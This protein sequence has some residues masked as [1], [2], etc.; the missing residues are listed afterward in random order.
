M[1]PSQPCA[2]Q[3]CRNA[4]EQYKQ[5][6]PKPL[7]QIGG[8]DSEVNGSFTRALEFGSDQ[9]REGCS[10]GKTDAALNI[11][12]AAGFQP[13]QMQFLFAP[14]RSLCGPARLRA[15][16]VNPVFL[17]VSQVPPGAEDR[18]RQDALGIVSLGFSVSFRRFLKRGGSVE[19]SPPQV[20][21]PHVA[22]LSYKLDDC[23]VLLLGKSRLAPTQ[24]RS[25][26]ITPGALSGLYKTIHCAFVYRKALCD[27]FHVSEFIA[28]FQERF[29]RFIVRHF[30]YL[31]L[32]I[33]HPPAKYMRYFYVLR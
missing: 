2:Y 1:S 26:Q 11:T 7:L 9:S 32:I 22:L 25:R 6:R 24:I 17:A 18:I 13:L 28:C 8:E 20:F 27:F 16:E 4:P 3:N 12:P 33:I 15:V 19:G 21:N 30:S 31:L 23:L 10:P 5:K 29:S 14:G